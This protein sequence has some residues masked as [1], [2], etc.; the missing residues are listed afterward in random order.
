MLSAV[1]GVTSTRSSDSAPGPSAGIASRAMT[2]TNDRTMSIAVPGSFT[3]G[4]NARLPISE[5]TINPK[6]GSSS[7]VRDRPTRNADANASRSIR[8]PPASSSE[9]TRASRT[10]GPTNFPGIASTETRMPPSS[11]RACNASRSTRCTYPISRASNGTPPVSSPGSRTRAA[12]RIR[13]SNVRVAARSARSTT[14]PS[15][16]SRAIPSTQR[17]NVSTTSASTATDISS[18]ADSP[19]GAKNPS[20]K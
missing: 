20:S 6:H 4:L 12:I 5:S 1:R 16:P 18:S 11:H 9:R 14:A 17:T 3:A 15:R 7:N 10:P 8:S 2:R 19:S 13:R